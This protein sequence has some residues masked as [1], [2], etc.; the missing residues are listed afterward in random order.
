M[1]DAGRV[2]WAGGPSAPIPVA[3]IGGTGYVAG[4]VA[5]LV[6]GHPAFS[7]QA[8]VSHAHAGE[9]VTTAFEHLAGV[10][11]DDIPFRGLPDWTEDSW[12]S[13]AVRGVFLAL[14]HGETSRVVSD[15]LQGKKPP[16]AHLVDLSADFRYPDADEFVRVYG[17][18]HAGRAFL[19]DF[20]CLIPEQHDGRPVRHAAHPGCFATAVTLAAWPFVRMGLVEGPVF[21]SAMTGSSGSGRTPRETTHHPARRSDLFAYSPLAHRHEPEMRRLIAHPDLAGPDVEF[22]AHSG[23]FVR[24]I[25]ATVR[26]TLR[27]AMPAGVLVER[28][29]EWYAPR[30]PFVRAS[31]VM[32]HLRAVVGTNRC[33]IGVAARGRTLVVTSVL[34][35]LL[36]GAAGGAVQWMNRAFG[37]PDDC[38]L[39]LAGPGWF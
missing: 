12:R 33:E 2:S 18:E 23:P 26:M 6:A 35:N 7:L 30:S 37:L 5:R 21:A 15:L 34:D 14:P 4:E 20:T 38:G 24:G 22:V 1:H 3:V 11:P 39:R 27:T 8:F 29:N 31:P 19:A 25:H 17:V 9:R 32:P 16:D 10:L 28:V 13:G 36:K